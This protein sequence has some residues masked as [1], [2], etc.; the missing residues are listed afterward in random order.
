MI[1]P[2][3]SSKRSAKIA[4]GNGSSQATQ[5]SSQQQRR[6]NNSQTGQKVQN[7]NIGN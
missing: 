6:K 2:S 1:I 3:A 7:F 5:S 4:T